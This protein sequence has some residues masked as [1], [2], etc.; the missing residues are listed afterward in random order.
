MSLPWLPNMHA[1]LVVN[2]RGTLSDDLCLTQNT[3]LVLFVIL[4]FHLQLR[5]YC[6]AAQESSGMPAV[7]FWTSHMRAIEQARIL[8]RMCQH[9]WT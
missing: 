4:C 2:S 8:S 9:L 6:T 7:A 3:Y 1:A 5:Q